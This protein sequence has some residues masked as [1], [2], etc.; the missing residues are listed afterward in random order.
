V[1]KPSTKRTV[2]KYLKEKYN[3]SK[4]LICDTIN[5]YRSTLDRESTKDDTETENKLNELADR[6]PTRG[7]DHYYGKIRMEGL[8]WNYKRVRRVYLKLGLKLR[9]KHKRRINRPYKE[10][11]CQPLYPN[12]TWSMDF[13]SDALEDGRKIRV[14]N[15]I[16]DYN[17]ESL[18]ITV[19]ISMSSERVT[20][21]L[22]ELV[23]LKGKPQGIRT[24]NGP[25]FTSVNYITWCETNNIVAKF[26]QPGKPNQNGYVE[27]FNRTF[28]EDVLDAYIFT[29][30][31]QMQMKADLWKEEY[32]N[33]HPHGSLGRLSPVAFK[34]SRSKFIDASDKVKAKMNGSLR[35][36]A[37]TLSPP[38]MATLNKYS[39]EKI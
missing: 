9:R 39:N 11:L 35:S 24:D 30:I 16:D 38:S 31:R 33:G 26:I 23:E 1:V 13:M 12:V 4:R 14:L 6:Y 36:P 32:N 17:R 15:I 8:I 21:I 10:A 22:D 37:L 28:R 29:S 20:R 19:G 27:R 5:L 2:Y 3:A 25:E 34:Y 7:M 18:S